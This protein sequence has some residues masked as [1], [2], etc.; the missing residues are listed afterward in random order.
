[1][2]MPRHR[3]ARLFGTI[4]M[5]VS[6]DLDAVMFSDLVS[7][8]FGLVASFRCPMKHHRRHE[9]DGKHEAEGADKL[10]HEA[11]RPPPNTVIR[12]VSQRAGGGSALTTDAMR[13]LSGLVKSFA[14]MTLAAAAEI[15]GC[16]A[17]WVW[18]RLGRSALWALPGIAALILF[19]W[20]LTRIDVAFAGRAFAAYGGIYITGSLL[21]L[22]QVEGMRP[23]RWDA[24]G[25]G[26]CIVGAAVIVFAPRA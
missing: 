5:R 25:A 10:V 9:G 8:M 15:G 26:L 16:F 1:M 23:D 6:V 14:Y 4:G 7:H 19:A 12:V 24:F 17:F 2:V 21:W 3:L 22:W 11:S 20:A 13:A 18:L